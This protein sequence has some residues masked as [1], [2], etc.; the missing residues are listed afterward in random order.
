MRTVVTILLLA[1]PLLELALLIKL[2]GWIGFWPTLLVIVVTAFVG[3]A[4]ARAQGF[5]V[6]RRMMDAS[7]QSRPPVEPVV[8]GALLFVAGGLLVSPGPIGDVLG[9]L[10]LVPPLRALAARW[11]V[12]RMARYGSIVTFDVRGARWDSGEDDASPRRPPLRHPHGGGEVIE[13]EFERIDERTGDQKKPK[14]G[15]PPS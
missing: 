11:I 8:E 13:G 4:V 15:D 12:S 3:V 7:S 10:L 14:R 5:G 1:A 9:L 6:L 2:G